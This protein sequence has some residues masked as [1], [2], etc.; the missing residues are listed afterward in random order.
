MKLYFISFLLFALISANEL[1]APPLKAIPQ[2]LS[3]PMSSLKQHHLISKNDFTLNATFYM[4]FL[5]FKQRI[6]ISF[7]YNRLGELDFEFTPDEKILTLYSR[8]FRFHKAARTFLLSAVNNIAYQ[9]ATGFMREASQSGSLVKTYPSLFI[10]SAVKNMAEKSKAIVRYNYQLSTYTNRVYS[11]QFKYLLGNG[12]RFGDQ[13]V[14]IVASINPSRVNHIL[15]L[16]RSDVPPKTNQKK[17][18]LDEL[19]NFY[20]NFRKRAETQPAIW[21]HTPIRSISLATKQAQNNEKLVQAIRD[22]FASENLRNVL[23]SHKINEANNFDW[24]ADIRKK[25]DRRVR[26][27][28]SQEFQQLNTVESFETYGGIPQ[29]RAWSNGNKELKKN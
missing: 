8:N 9:L 10:F 16:L 20:S 6:E 24:L 25:G 27:F 22:N 28:I 4:R 29:N 19:V 18:Q 5:R 26:K 11:L 14:K 12:L 2:S 23:R 17:S 7:F 21:V 1:A 3:A 13:D 15:K